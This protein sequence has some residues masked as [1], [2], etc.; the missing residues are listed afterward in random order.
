MHIIQ[1]PTTLTKII[2]TTINNKTN[3]NTTKNKNLINTFHP[4]SNILYNLTT[5]K[6]LPHNNFITKLN[7][8][9]KY[10]FITNPTILKLIKHNPTTTTT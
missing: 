5:L 10:N 3:I 8:I 2:N 4:P 9:I 1:I 7:K 6:T